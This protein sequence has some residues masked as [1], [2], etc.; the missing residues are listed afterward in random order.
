M[1]A[2]EDRQETGRAHESSRRP[3]ARSPVQVD[4]ELAR[5]AL[6]SQPFSV[7]LGSRLVE[8]DP[9]GAT[10][11]LEVRNDLRQQHGFV[12]GGVISYLVDNAV[13]FAA[14]AVLGPD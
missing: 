2:Y 12:H 10:L 6:A 13:T 3:E 1:T 8:F 5:A 4:I 14:G 7:L 9:E 11:E